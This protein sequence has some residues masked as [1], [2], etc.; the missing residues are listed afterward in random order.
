MIRRAARRWSSIRRWPIRSST[1]QPGAAGRS[2]QI[3]NTHWHGDHIGGNAGIV[4][5][6]GAKVTA[7]TAELAEI[8]NV[9]RSGAEGD[10]VRLGDHDA[11]VWEVPAHTAGHIAYLFA[12]DSLV[13]VGDTLFAMG[14]GRLFEGTPAQMFRNMARLSELPGDTQVYCA[15]EYT[16]SNGKY[17]IRAE[18]GESRRRRAACD[19]RGDARARR[20]HRAHR[21][22]PQERATNPFMRGRHGRGTGPPPRREGQRLGIDDAHALRTV[23]DALPGAVGE[24]CT[25]PRGTSPLSLLYKVGGKM[26]AVMTLRG[27][28]YVVIKAPPFV[29]DMLREHICRRRQADPSRSAPLGRHRSRVRRAGRGDRSARAELLMNWSARACPGRTAPRSKRAD[30]DGSDIIEMA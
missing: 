7:P 26:F 12:D 22:S 23:L 25:P 6:T 17:A 21:P 16:L 5:A 10:I 15:H 19:G 3:W 30:G 14:C 1:P 18:P 13:F 27:A 9:D 4:A 8:P 20:G 11:T 2:A 24:P 29:C 28:L